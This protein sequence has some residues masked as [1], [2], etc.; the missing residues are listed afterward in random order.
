MDAIYNLITQHTSYEKSIKESIENTLDK[1]DKKQ[2]QKD[3]ITQV[4]NNRETIKNK[5]R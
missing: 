3:M 1:K 5:K 4:K 2:K